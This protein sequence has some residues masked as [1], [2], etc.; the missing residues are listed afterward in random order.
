MQL[1]W[2]SSVETCEGT[3]HAGAPLTIHPCSV[4]NSLGPTLVVLSA[5]RALA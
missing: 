2:H 1:E 4:V 5:G 3:G